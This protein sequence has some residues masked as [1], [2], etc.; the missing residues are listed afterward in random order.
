MEQTASYF[1]DKIIVL[2]GANGGLGSEMALQLIASGARLILSDVAASFDTQHEQILAYIQSDLLKKNGCREFVDQIHAICP[3]VDILI[4]NAGIGSLGDLVDTPDE[5]WEATIELN[6]IVPLRLTKMF[7][8]QMIKKRSGHI[9]NISSLAAHLAIPQVTPYIASKFAL[10]G[11]GAALQ[12]EVAE[13]NIS[14]STVYPFFTPTPILESARYGQVIQRPTMPTYL[15][16]NRQSVIKNLLEGVASK[17]PH[18]FPSWRAKTTAEAVRF[19]PG[20]V[21][22]I[23]KNIWRWIE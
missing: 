12:A 17:Y 16:D 8:P 5:K 10:R 9:V 15:L 21:D 11:F 6:L 3:S 4:N 14:I 22:F 7:L 1:R 13:Y 19:M 23:T 20:A 2:T 18:I